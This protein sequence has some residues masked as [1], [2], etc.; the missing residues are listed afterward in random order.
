MKNKLKILFLFCFAAMLFFSSCEKEI[1]DNAKS[2]SQQITNL[3]IQKINYSKLISNKKVVERLKKVALKKLPNNIAQRAV[4]NEEFNVMIDTTNIIQIISDTEQSFTFSIVNYSDIFKFENLV[5]VSKNEGSFDAYITEYNLTQQ[6]LDI[7]ANGGSLENIELTSITNIDEASKMELGPCV[8]IE[9]MCYNNAGETIFNNGESGNDCHGM[10]FYVTT[11]NVDCFLGSG[12]GGGTTGG[13]N[14]P[15]GNTSGSTTT[16]NTGG[17]N[18]HGGGNGSNNSN[19]II[20]SPIFEFEEEE[21]CDLINKLQLDTNFKNRMFGLV[22]SANNYSM[23]ITTVLTDNP[24][25]HPTNNFTY[26]VPFSGDPYNPSMTYSADTNMV[27]V[28]HSHY[29]GLLSIF[30]ATDL[31]DLYLN[32]KN[33]PA[34]TDNIFLAVVTAS[35]TAYLLQIK[36]RTAFIAFGDK[37]LSNDKDRKK[38]EKE[39]MFEKYKISQNASNKTNE[40]GFLKMMSNLNMGASIASANLTTLGTPSSSLFNRWDKKK[41]DKKTGTVKSTK[42]N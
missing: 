34:I 41:W 35:N 28:I 10:G 39:T 17:S 5:L 14:N 26:S 36:D 24:D 2:Q 42:C 30:S 22:Y 8:T 37:H 13:Y 23:E 40:D 3:N 4:Y 11:I 16:G 25:P 31:Q 21:S 18:T 1:Y 29:D 7:L 33:Y 20:T 12:G 38:F 19:P 6:D 9:S 15:S 27:A 32:L